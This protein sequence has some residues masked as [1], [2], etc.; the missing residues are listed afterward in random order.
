MHRAATR[1]AARRILGQLPPAAWKSLTTTFVCLGV[2]FAISGLPTYE[3]LSSEGVRAL[4]ILLLCAGL[5]VTEA[6]PAFSVSLLA[7]GLEVA[8]LGDSASKNGDWEKYLA[9]W[10]S[11]LIWLFFG[12]FVLAAAA[13]KTGLDLWMASQVL[14]RLGDRPAIVLLGLM[15]VTVVLSMFL[16]NTATATMMVAVLS[17]MLVSSKREAPYPRALLLGIAMAAN[18]GGMG[19]IIGTPPNAIAAAALTSGH[20]VNFAQWMVYG[21]PPATIMLAIA[22]GY[23]IYAHLPEGSFSPSDS[24]QL[25]K[26]T[27]SSS[28]PRLQQA[29]VILA[30]SVT[31]LLWMT[32][33]LHGLPTTVVSLIPICLLTATG[34]LEGNDIRGLSWDVLLL[35]AGGLSLGVAVSDTGLAS[36]LVAQLPFEGMS[37]L[38]MTLAIAYVTI[39]LSNLMSNTATANLILPIF[40]VL[41][42]SREHLAIPVAL[43][44]SAAMCLPIS[45]PPNAIVYGTNRLRSADLL[46][47]GLLIGLVA[48]PITLAWVT[49]VTT[50]TK[51]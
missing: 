40:L 14:R 25:D 50:V 21:I 5:W 18:V 27:V 42:G 39:V 35:I 36:W 34:V 13:K 32:S 8:L 16:S 11:P 2:A 37:A 31:I 45:T 29:I 30:F 6:M 41:I 22:W 19:T 20:E 24:A 23:L 46:R 49:I 12:G 51:W 43:S 28:V 47:A 3:G 10:G 33:P 1:Y 48:P 7:I 44:A 4:F 9:T 15:I 38:V 17:P 26:A